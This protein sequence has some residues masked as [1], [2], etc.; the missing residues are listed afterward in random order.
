MFKL[1]SKTRAH[2]SLVI[3]VEPI[4]NVL[5]IK[6]DALVI[7]DIDIGT[8]LDGP[9]AGESPALLSAITVKV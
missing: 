9:D 5:P 6:F 2:I 7:F 1:K 8:K 4:T 3:A